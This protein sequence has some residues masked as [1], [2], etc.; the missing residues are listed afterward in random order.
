[1]KNL[2][3][4]CTLVFLIATQAFADSESPYKYVPKSYKDVVSPI[5]LENFP[6]LRDQSVFPI[7]QTIASYY[8][9]TYYYCKVN[10]IVPCSE[11]PPEKQMSILDLS[12]RCVDHS[13]LGSK[14]RLSLFEDKSFIGSR[15]ESYC[16]LNIQREGNLQ[17]ELCFSWDKFISKFNHDVKMINS[18]KEKIEKH[19]EKYRKNQ[20]EGK[21]CQE[22]FLR[23]FYEGFFSYEKP[24]GF[25]MP[26][27]KNIMEALEETAE[28]A[29]RSPD[30]R[31]YEILWYELLV[32]S[33]QYKRSQL[34][35]LEPDPVIQRRPDLFREIPH[36]PDIESVKGKVVEVLKKGWPLA[37]G[38]CT[39]KADKQSDCGG[40]ALVISGY[41]RVCNDSGRCWDLFKL[42]N[43]Y[44]ERSY[45][46]NSDGSL[47][48][49]FDAD[50][51]L[52]LTPPPWISLE[53]Y[54][55]PTNP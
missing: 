46:R 44:G 35:D 18:L 41:R 49:W 20:S 6:R 9:A 21:F 1:M 43:T 28:I 11:L 3:Q 45:G 47:N 2:F 13:G 30:R 38:F 37:L 39:R 36:L 52:S 51:L 29:A 50:S 31:V 24:A 33:C 53:W 5:E 26:P 23:D 27:P 55:M 8:I 15:N 54:E 19:F 32:G 12:E 17:S 40:H 25:K 10:N 14:F 7:C 16:L 48:K 34:I 42:E 4:I 22:C